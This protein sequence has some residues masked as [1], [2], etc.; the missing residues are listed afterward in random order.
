MKIQRHGYLSANPNY[1]DAGNNKQMLEQEIGDV[2]HAIHRMVMAGDI[3]T[4]AIDRAQTT[5][6]ISIK[7]YLH[8]Q[9]DHQCA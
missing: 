4:I 3:S 7:P 8:H 2:R 5:K 6:A 9:E 1:P